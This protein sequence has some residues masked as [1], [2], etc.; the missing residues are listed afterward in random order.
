MRRGD[1]ALKHLQASATYFYDECQKARARVVKLTDELIRVRAAWD[2]A[3]LK[4]LSHQPAKQE[5]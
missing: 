2:E 5:P 4:A 1:G 3:Q